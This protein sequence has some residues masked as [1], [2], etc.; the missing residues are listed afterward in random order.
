MI[1]RGRQVVLSYVQ[2]INGVAQEGSDKV[3]HP[4]KPSRLAAYSVGR[5]KSL[6]LSGAFCDQKVMTDCSA[7]RRRSEC[8]RALHSLR[9]CTRPWQ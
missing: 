2:K 4:S 5:S 9:L 1:S 3:S 8:E 6:G 7:A